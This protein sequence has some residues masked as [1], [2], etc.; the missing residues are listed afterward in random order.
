MSRSRQYNFMENVTVITCI[1]KQSVPGHL[2]V[3]WL[4]GY[5]TPIYTVTTVTIV[6]TCH[7]IAITLS[8]HNLTLIQYV[9][10][11]YNMT[12]WLALLKLVYVWSSSWIIKCTWHK[13]W[14]RTCLS[15]FH[16]VLR[17]VGLLCVVKWWDYSFHGFAHDV[18]FLCSVLS[19]LKYFTMFCRSGYASN[20]QE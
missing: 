1:H 5:S 8:M 11:V 17:E 14:E 4:Q 19:I 13:I 6:T 2:F 18:A 16:R 9:C 15:Q 12:E 20:M 3:A 7:H 10:I